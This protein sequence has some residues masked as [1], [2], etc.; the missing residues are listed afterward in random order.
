MLSNC[1]TGEDSWESLGLQGDQT[2]KETLKKIKPEYSLEELMLK[3]KLQYFNYVMWRADTLEKTLMLGKTEGSR[4]RGQQRMREL[5]SIT[6]SMDMNL[7]KLQ[8]MVEIRRAWHA[9]VHGVTKSQTW[10][11]NWTVIRHCQVSLGCRGSL[12]IESHYCRE[13]TGV[14]FK[15]R[16]VL[17]PQ[18]I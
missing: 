11:S 7:G 18:I 6:D 3:L 5:D 2:S 8:E 17:I 14:L 15:L 1:G 9:I 13:S 4:S 10:L 16:G 12:H